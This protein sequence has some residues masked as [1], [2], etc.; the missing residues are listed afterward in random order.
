MDVAKGEAIERIARVLAGQ[1]L[2]SNAGG[3]DPSAATA[4]DDSW[5]FYRDDAIAILHTLRA[6]D[7]AMARAGDPAVWEAMVAA[8]LGDHGLHGDDGERGGQ[9]MKP[10]LDGV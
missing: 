9:L 6:P 5:R 2:S 8:A 10:P 3:T 4:V 1:R 7:Q